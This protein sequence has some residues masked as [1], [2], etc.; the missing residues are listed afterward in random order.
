M[1]QR[2][3]AI[4]T[5]KKITHAMRL[6]SMSTHTRL[7]AKKKFL[8]QYQQELNQLFA[9][10]HTQVSDWDHAIMFPKVKTNPILAILVGSQKGLCGNFNPSLYYFAEKQLARMNKQQ[11]QIITIGKKMSAYATV[12]YG[13]IIKEYNTFSFNTVESITKEIS[14]LIINAPQPY[15]SVIIFANYPK[16]FFIQQPQKTIAIPFQT[17]PQTVTPEQ[18][19]WEQEPPLI[20]DY[21][22]NHLIY[23]NILECFFMSLVSEQ[24]ARFIA[25]DSSTRNATNL[26]DTMRLNYNK[27]RQTKITRELTDLAGS[28][29]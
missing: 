29:F 25:M 27:L 20:L 2:I 26:L 1:R 24:A 18:F 19:M 23:M 5:I 15:S 8:E 17:L 7:R 9:S 14:E 16:S 4:E 21:L 3:K 13:T 6:I 28:F 12:G 22:A 11:L 10:I